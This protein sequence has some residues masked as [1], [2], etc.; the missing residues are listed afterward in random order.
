MKKLLA[1]FSLILC[2]NAYAILPG[3]D[4][5]EF[6]EIFDAPAP[7]GDKVN[8]TDKSFKIQSNDEFLIEGIGPKHN[9]LKSVYVLYDPTNRQ[10]TL[11]AMGIVALAVD[12]SNPKAVT[13][14][15]MQLMQKAIK[16]AVINDKDDI[17]AQSTIHGHTVSLTM[18]RSLGGL[19]GIKVQ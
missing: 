15:I 6:A 1:F 12:H 14:A 10:N 8:D 4:I 3:A 11:L 7:T 18:Y 19:I 2:V 13:P 16:K 17:D 5:N 9:S